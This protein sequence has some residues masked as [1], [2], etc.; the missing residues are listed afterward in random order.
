MA[1]VYLDP[2]HGGIDPGATGCGKREAD[3]ALDVAKRVC[4][5]L[6]S[7]YFDVKMSRSSNHTPNDS[8][9]NADLGRRAAEANAWGADIYVSVHLN[10]GHGHGVE[11][12]RSVAGGKSTTLATDIQTAVQ[13][14][15]GMPA[16]G[17]PVKTK[18]GDGGH[19]WICVIRES[20]MPTCLVECGFIDNPRD[21]NGWNANKYALG[22]YN[23]ICQYFGAA[24]ATLISAQNKS[25]AIRYAPA[26]A[27]FVSDT[28][29]TVK[30]KRG[31]YYK[32]E[33]TCPSGRPS[34]T[35]GK[36]SIADITYQSRS[37]NNYYFRITATGKTGAETGIYINGHKPSTM[38]VRVVT[39]CDS[40][41]TVNL[42]RKVGEC[43][44]VGLTCPTKPSVTVD[45][46]GVVTVA[47][48]FADGAGKWLCPIVAVKPGVT[49]IYTEVADE[50]NP[51]KRF[52]FAVTE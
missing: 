6:P 37:G 27:A 23:G 15:T 49:G 39:M 11:T 5:L 32:V 24:Q 8:N 35:A 13:S 19:D 30:L 45:T 17:E 21:M 38:V 52:E 31:Q 22:I 51:V 16:H 40:D 14:A 34:L 12:Y 43:Y 36:G 41:T 50:G 10:A 1:K 4:A 28:T 46:N 9:P 33:V 25:A 26:G 3:C 42:S 2:G 20:N 18:I 47:G 48:V 7:K 29:T 44:T